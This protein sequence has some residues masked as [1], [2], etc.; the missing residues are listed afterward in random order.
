LGTGLV[1]A[2]LVETESGHVLVDTGP[3]NRRDEL[4]AG[5]RQAGCRPE[6]L[7]LI[8]LTHGDFDHTGN[9]AYLR[10]KYGCKVAIHAADV[11]M[12]ESGDMFWNRDSGNGVIR[13][14]APILYRFPKSSRIS[15]DI[16]LED[17]RDLGEFG[18][19]AEVVGLPGHS[20]GSIGVLSRGGDLFCG[21]LLENIAK[22]SL[23]SIMDNVAAADASIERL[24]SLDIGLVYPGHGQP[25]AM[26]DFLE[27]RSPD[28]PAPGGDHT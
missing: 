22:P 10:Q 21:D 19:N 25:F 27:A 11:G 5:L 14:L 15:P 7:K 2:Y 1:N 4:E 13:A 17:G 20:R 8:V 16:L 28:P 23:G 6:S 3:G 12:L 18:F 24:A 9:C 26:A